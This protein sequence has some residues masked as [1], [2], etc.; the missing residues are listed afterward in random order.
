MP[1]DMRRRRSRFALLLVVTFGAVVL[2]GCL[3]AAPPPPP[4]PTPPAPVAGPVTDYAS[5]VFSDPWDFSNPEDFDTTPNVVSGNVTNLSMPGG[6]LHLDTNG[7]GDIDLARTIMGSI[8]YGRDS[9]AH[10][11]DASKYTA[12]TFSMRSTAADNTSTG[13]VMYF[14]CPQLS[15][16]CQGNVPFVKRGGSA[17][18]TYDFN[19]TGSH[20]GVAWSGLVYGVRIIPAST[21]ASI[22]FDWIRL[23]AASAP[24]APPANPAPLPVVDSP[25]ALGGADYA[26]T[27]RGDAWDFSQPSDV[28]SSANV[29][30]GVGNGLLNGY[31]VGPGANDGQIQLPLAAPIDGSR[32][33]HLT[34]RVW[35]AG[36]FGLQAGPGGGM[37]ARL[38]WSTVAHPGQYQDLDDVVVYP[39]WNTIQLDL[40]TDP[41]GAIVDPNTPFTHWGWWGQQIDF[42]R[43][44]PD[45]DSGSRQFLVDDIRITADASGAGGF[46]IQFHDNAW[47]PGTTADVYAQATNGASTLLGTVAMTGPGATF[48]WI[49][50]PAGTWRTYVVLKDPSGQQ[51]LRYATGPVTIT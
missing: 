15:P 11:I 14:T 2:A 7:S 3:P 8:P 33:H 37:V 39:G 36:P 20:G 24:L 41:P 19:L 40:A 16:A 5:D 29:V 30:W 22:D 35:Y 43:F 46:P 17:F 44:D 18:T 49:G 6:L 32:Y 47:E 28:A 34:I 23:R 12:L 26:A 31:T 38:I 4:P 25:S 48:N 1:R 51:S 50:A 21:T 27:V 9:R 13:Q 42:L 10:P 45:E